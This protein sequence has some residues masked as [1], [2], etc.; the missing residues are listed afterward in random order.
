[1]PGERL[2]LRLAYAPERFM[3]EGAAETLGRLERLL[4][5]L[6][7]TAEAG[8]LLGDLPAWEDRP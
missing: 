7:E 4:T 6:A 1:V 2:L 8:G 5:G 3:A